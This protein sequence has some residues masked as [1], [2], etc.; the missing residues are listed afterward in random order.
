Q[1]EFDE[2][3]HQAKRIG[4]APAHLA[5]AQLGAARAPLRATVF[6]QDDRKVS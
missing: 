2:N 3:V 1:F 5:K 6:E 4:R